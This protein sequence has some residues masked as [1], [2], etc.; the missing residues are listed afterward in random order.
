[1]HDTRRGGR[2]E[3]I[4]RRIAGVVAVF[5]RTESKLQPV[6]F[7]TAV[8]AS[9]YLVGQRVLKGRDRSLTAKC[10]LVVCYQT[11]ATVGNSDGGDGDGGGASDL[12]RAMAEGGGGGGGVTSRWRRSSLCDAS[13]VWSSAWREEISAAS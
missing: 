11:V 13:S 8:L 5:H 7:V 1:M 10:K 12:S 6:Y 2:G 9:S 4:P 3:R